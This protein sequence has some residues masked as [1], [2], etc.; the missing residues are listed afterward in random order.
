MFMNVDLPLP[1]APTTARNVPLAICR[2]SPRRACTVTSP[3]TYDFLRST[4]WTRGRSP[5]A[6]ASA[7][8]APLGLGREGVRRARR[9]AGARAG[10]GAGSGRPRDDLGPLVEAAH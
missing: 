2:S 9:S 1:D 10:G 3:T 8:L 4:M 6:T 7:P 5:S